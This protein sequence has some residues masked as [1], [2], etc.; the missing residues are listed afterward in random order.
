MADITHQG[1]IAP[2]EPLKPPATS[3]GIIGWLRAN[4]FNSAFNTILTL[5]ALWAIVATVPG[6][7]DWAFVHAHW[8]AGT[9]RECQEAGAGAC[10][11]FIGEKWRFILFG[12]FP[13]EEHW[14]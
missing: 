2:A 12:R 6:F 13:Y 10:W 7:V 9:G 5:L 14:R 8:H 1:H 11:A 4:L 3:L